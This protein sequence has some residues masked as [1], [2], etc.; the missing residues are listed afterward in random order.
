MVWVIELLQQMRYHH[1]LE[2]LLHIELCFLI[3][4]PVFLLTVMLLSVLL[5]LLVLDLKKRFHYFYV[6]FLFF[7]Y[8]R[9]ARKI[10]KMTY[11]TIRANIN[12]VMVNHFILKKLKHKFRRDFLLT[13][14][15]KY[16]LI[17][18]LMS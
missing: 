18:L 11:S 10:E 14:S 13:M 2:H 1:R 17:L 15:L 5:Y 7:V 8:C 3:L 4:M 9:L 12:P 16:F 6:F